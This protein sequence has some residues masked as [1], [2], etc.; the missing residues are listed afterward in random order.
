MI[1]NNPSHINVVNIAV[2]ELI[3]WHNVKSNTTFNR[4]HSAFAFIRKFSF[5][6]KNIT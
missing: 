4:P 3:H 5:L 2:D 6:N 1:W